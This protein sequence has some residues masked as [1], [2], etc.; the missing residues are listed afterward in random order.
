MQIVFLAIANPFDFKS[1]AGSSRRVLLFAL[2][3]NADRIRRVPSPSTHR[4]HDLAFGTAA[5]DIGERLG[6]FCERKRPVDDDIQLRLLDQ[7]AKLGQFGAT[8]MHEQK[9]IADF[10]AASAR[11][12]FAADDPE[13]GGKAVAAVEVLDRGL[14][15]RKSCY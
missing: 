5:F 6:Y 15:F 2:Q 12:D 10:C 1:R 14:R 9:S 11:S 4:H 13:Q 7:F 8:W 3:A